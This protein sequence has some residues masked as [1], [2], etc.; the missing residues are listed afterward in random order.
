MLF[1]AHLVKSAESPESTVL[2]LILPRRNEL[3]VMQRNASM[4]KFGSNP[5]TINTHLKGASTV[6]EKLMQALCFAAA[7]P[8]YY[9]PHWVAYLSSNL[10]IY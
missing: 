10:L 3:G 8:F 9:L 6:D 5:P 4:P 2:M 1:S 7:Q